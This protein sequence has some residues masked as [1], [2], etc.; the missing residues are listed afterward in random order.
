MRCRS[1]ICTG[2]TGAGPCRTG[3]KRCGGISAS[4]RRPKMGATTVTNWPGF[5]RWSIL[6]GSSAR[7]FGLR[8]SMSNVEERVRREAELYDEQALQRSGLEKM[9]EYVDEGIGRDRRNEV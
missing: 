6:Q 1:P 5:C 8:R 3:S 4:T 2:T 7:K 9:L